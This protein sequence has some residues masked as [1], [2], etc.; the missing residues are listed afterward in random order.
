[1]HNNWL[2]KRVFASHDAIVDHYFDAWNRLTDHPW[3]VMSIELR[4]WSRGRSL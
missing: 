2:A 3:R 4:D 1:M